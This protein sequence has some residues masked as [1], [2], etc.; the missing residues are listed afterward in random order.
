MGRRGSRTSLQ[1][2][3]LLRTFEDSVEIDGIAMDQASC[4]D[5]MLEEEID[6]LKIF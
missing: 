1:C 5:S 3:I 2:Y 4:L 6:Y